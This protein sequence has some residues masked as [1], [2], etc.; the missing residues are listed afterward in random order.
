MSFNKDRI[1][2]RCRSKPATATHGY[3]RE[4]CRDYM[5]KYYAAHRERSNQKSKEH[6]A[7]IRR[8]VQAEKRRPCCDCG[9]LYSP[10]VMDFD[11]RTGVE[12]KFRLAN[13][14]SK[15][16]EDVKQEIAKCDVV[17][18]NCHRVRTARRR[19]GLPATLPPPDYEI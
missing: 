10:E 6:Q 3:C 7:K 5:R 14:G 16:P 4:C 18:A 15:N 2:S 19:Q 9:N 1:C 13:A 11:H 12:K 8:T 17:C